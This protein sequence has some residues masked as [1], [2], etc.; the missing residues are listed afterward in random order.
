[1]KRLR[2]LFNLD[3]GLDAVAMDHR[4]VGLRIMPVRSKVGRRRPGKPHRVAVAL[5]VT[6]SREADELITK[7]GA[8]KLACP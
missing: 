8:N 2:R 7:R 6:R 3:V 5:F 4:A 1:M